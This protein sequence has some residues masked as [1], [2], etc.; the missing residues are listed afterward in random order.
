MCDAL[1]KATLA[2]Q[3]MACYSVTCRGEVSRRLPVAHGL[4][5]QRP[6]L[7]VYPPLHSNKSQF[8]IWSETPQLTIHSC[9]ISSDWWKFDEYWET[10]NNTISRFKLLQTCV[11]SKQNNLICFSSSVLQFTK[12][13]TNCFSKVQF[14]SIKTC[15][16]LQ[17][18]SNKTEQ[19]KIT[20]NRQGDLKQQKWTPNMWCC[21]ISWLVFV[22]VR[23]VDAVRLY[24]HF[25][26]DTQTLV[27][28]LN[29]C[30][31]ITQ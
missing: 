7:R 23:W 28:T 12:Y 29:I 19:D 15:C 1:D 21:V 18:T 24:L 9:K 8:Q 20:E 6:R 3:E 27:S 30:S 22:C 17:Y 5:I 25:Q 10:V 4:L 2:Q 26:T 31:S 16:V 14:Y 11:E 13:P